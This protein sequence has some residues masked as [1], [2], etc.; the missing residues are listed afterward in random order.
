[1]GQRLQGSKE[2]NQCQV[3]IFHLWSRGDVITEEFVLKKVR[4]FYEALQENCGSWLLCLYG[5]REVTLCWP[6]FKWRSG[7]FS[8][9]IVAASWALQSCSQCIHAPGDSSSVRLNR[10]G[11]LLSPSR[12]IVCDF[13]SALLQPSR[14]QEKSVSLGT[15][16]RS[17]NFSLVLPVNLA[18]NQVSFKGEQL[19]QRSSLAENTWQLLRIPISRCGGFSSVSLTCLVWRIALPFSNWFCFL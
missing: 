6:G 10:A 17:S 11:A 15:Q 1:M 3:D 14:W 2:W 5:V 16:Q 8:A 4:L 7:L 13:V 12:A 18:V 19:G 9:V